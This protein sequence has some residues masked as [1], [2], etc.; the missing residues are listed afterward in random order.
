MVKMTVIFSI[1]SK[2]LSSEPIRQVKE[3]KFSTQ[4]FLGR[5]FPSVS[6]HFWRPS[7]RLLSVLFLFMVTAKLF[8]SLFGLNLSFPGKFQ[9][10]WIDFSHINRVTCWSDENGK[11]LNTLF[12]VSQW[13]L[14]IFGRSIKL[15]MQN[16]E[17]KMI[18]DWNLNFFFSAFYENYK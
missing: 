11:R 9:F 8:I 15:W 13:K 10:S 16:V 12:R 14:T 7:R 2:R 6:Q 17:L 4:W 3:Q 18:S 1:D 5:F